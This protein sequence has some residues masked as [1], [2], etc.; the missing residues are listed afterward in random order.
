VALADE[1]VDAIELLVDG[2][3]RAVAVAMTT[4]SYATAFE[5]DD[6]PAGPETERNERLL[7]ELL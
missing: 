5:R 3:F 4:P 1:L 6:M 2:Q 7:V